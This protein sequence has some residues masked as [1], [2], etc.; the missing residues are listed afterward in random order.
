VG[1]PKSIDNDILLI[2]KCF[3]FDTAVEE[4]QRA[5]LAA[6]VEASSARHGIGLVKLM[7]RQ[8]GFIA[9]QA[10]LASG[11]C[12]RARAQA[13]G[14]APWLD[15]R[16]AGLSRRRARAGACGCARAPPCATAL[17]CPALPC[18]TAGVAD[19]CL[20]P[21]VPF[22]LY[23]ERGMF[24]YLEKVRAGA[25]LLGPLGPWRPPAGGGLAAVAGHGSSARNPGTPAAAGLAPASTRCSTTAALAL[26][27]VLKKKGHAVVCVAEGAGQDL[28]EEE[29]GNGATDAS[30]NPILKDIGARP[31]A[32]PAA[33]PCWL[34][35]CCLLPAGAGPCSTYCSLPAPIP[36]VSLM[37]SSKPSV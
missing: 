33:A 36:I 5:L 4:A 8:S 26:L 34:L 14:A 21:E 28:L 16:R 35:A 6:K 17:P 7:G 32:P 18:P 31:S 22:K 12:T 11:G 10:S 3:G 30:G 37:S 13:L 19:V 27:Q 15:T 1:V 23:G 25:V 29:G 24:A 9:M 20:I 2:D